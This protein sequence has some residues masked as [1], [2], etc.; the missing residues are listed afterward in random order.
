MNFLTL[1]KKAQSLKESKI[2]TDL[3]KFIKSIEKVFID[4]NIDQIEE[5]KNTQG[6]TL[7]NKIKKFSSGLYSESTAEFAKIDGVTTPKKAGEPYNFLWT[8]DFLKSFDLFTKNGNV[9]ILST[10]TGSGDKSEFFNGFSD[11]FGL[12][13]EN[14]KKVIDKDLLPFLINYY[15]KNLFS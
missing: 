14:L 2:R 4:L 1:Q 15:Q 11:M 10:G 5:H 3:F 8:G 13:D 12:T 7:K 6:K 9:T